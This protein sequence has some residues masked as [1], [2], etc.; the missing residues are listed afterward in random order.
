M[1]D[2][3]MKDLTKIILVFVTFFA[4]GTAQVCFAQ[5]SGGTGTES[6]PYLISTADDMVALSYNPNDWNKHFKMIADID[7]SGMI[8]NIIGDTGD[9]GEPP[10]AGV[11]DGNGHVISNYTLTYGPPTWRVFDV[12]LFGYV[13]SSGVIKNLVM[14]Q[15]NIGYYFEPATAG[16]LAGVNDGTIENCY[17]TGTVGGPAGNSFFGGLVGQNHGTIKNSFAVGTIGGGDDVGGFAGINTGAIENCYFVGSIEAANDRV[18]G[19]VGINIGTIKDS[20]SATS[21]HC[22][23]YSGGLVAIN[24]GT[25]ENCFATGSVDAA[26]ES[27]GGLVAANTGTIINSYATGGAAWGDYTGGLVGSNS[28]IIE[29]SYATGSVISE[30]YGGGLAGTNSGT[31]KNSYAMGSVYGQYYLI[32]GGLVGDNS[33]TIEDTYSV[34]SVAGNP[35]SPLGGLMGVNSNLT[36]F[37]FWDVDT[38]GQQTSAGGTGLHTPDMWKK[39]TF[40]NAGWDFTNT[41]TIRDGKD[42]PRLVWERKLDLI[43]SSLKVLSTACESVSISAA[44]KNNGLGLTPASI[45]S[46]Y[47]S[48]NSALD[49]GDALVGS[50]SIPPLGPGDSYSGTT[51]LEIPPG[52]PFGKYYIIAKADDSKAITETNESNNTR[53]ATVTLAPDLIVSVLAAPA[54]A[55]G[56]TIINVTDSTKN[57]GPCPAPVSSTYYY[58]STNTTL[59]AGD[60]LLGSRLIPELSV[61]E[62]ST[63]G[64]SLTLPAD[65]TAGKYY[66]I[67]KADGANAVFETS[68]T[69]NTRSKSIM[70]GPDLTVSSLSAPSS[71]HVGAAINIT[72]TT[73]NGGGG[74]SPASTTSFYLSA[75]TTLD[76]GDRLLG[77]R[78]V[79]ALGPGESNTGTISVTI[80]LDVTPGAYYIIAKADDSNAITETNESNNTRS[81]N[82]T[83]VP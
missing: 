42:Y 69:N 77:S 63:G 20:Y 50:M 38:S 39:L 25:I 47:L 22:N 53:C 26:Y 10:F 8:L 15:V 44:T 71:A 73:K 58:F 46:F 17:T 61:G 80:P 2:R 48:T 49:S 35:P 57:N 11:F 30:Y 6:D 14:E 16:G 34:G 68:E 76:S 45:T 52:T 72:E 56:G 74:T 29:T 55:G 7:L 66:I 62:S 9:Y 81:R 21:F 67:A 4:I 5:Y 59:D 79:L 60:M 78:P 18:G 28:G 1:R 54:T 65:L 32:G 37:S 19:L 23:T 31:I 51:T 40:L 27:V 41:W 3:S 75:N 64:V 13:G 43:V 70:I 36:N 24:N 12:G 82:I 83:I 33:G